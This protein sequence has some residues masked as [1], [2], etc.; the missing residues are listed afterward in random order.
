MPQIFSAKADRR[1]RQLLLGIA[2]VVVGGGALLFY[3][4]RSDRY[5]GVG[6]TIDQPVRFRHDI[7]VAE[8]GLDCTYCHTG[9]T[10]V[11]AADMPAASTCLG[12]HSHLWRGVEA[13]QPLFTSV[14]L[15]Q[16]I[17]WNSLYRLPEHSRFHHGAHVASGIDCATCH[18]DVQNMVKTEKAKPMSMAWCLDCHREVGERRQAALVDRNPRLADME[19][20]NPQLTDCSVCHY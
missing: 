4:V 17:R 20:A 19:L 5:W 8:L 11:A 2:I 7:H 10:R 13:L 16:P 6:D 18:G 3:I 9:A 15:T 1:L 14:E 12:C